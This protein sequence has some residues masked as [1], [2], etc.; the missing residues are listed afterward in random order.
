MATAAGARVP[1]A[2]GTTTVADKTASTATLT[3]AGTGADKAK[4]GV[5][6]S[7]KRSS[8][9]VKLRGSVAGLSRGLP[10]VEAPREAN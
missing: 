6:S 5:A 3:G 7:T 8:G 1:A 10:V 9:R 2:V 4:S